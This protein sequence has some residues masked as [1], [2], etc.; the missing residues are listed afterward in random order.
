MYKI[1]W[2]ME[3]EGTEIFYGLWN[4]HPT[5]FLKRKED[6]EERKKEF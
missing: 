1:E 5:Y 3:E 6:N 2:K 4:G